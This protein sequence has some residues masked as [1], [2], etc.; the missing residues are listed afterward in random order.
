MNSIDNNG[1]GKDTLSAF[2]NESTS[3]KCTPI[4]SYQNASVMAFYALHCENKA[5]YRAEDVGRTIVLKRVTPTETREV[6]G[7]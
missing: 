3:Y 1:P 7:N 2:T 4:M 5:G 6:W